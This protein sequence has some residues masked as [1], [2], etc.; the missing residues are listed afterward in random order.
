MQSPENGSTRLHVRR[1]LAKSNSGWGHLREMPSRDQHWEP[2]KS[3]R[4]RASAQQQGEPVT[5][6][7]DDLIEALLG[8][9]TDSERDGAV[10]YLA[11]EPV[12][13]GEVVNV[14]GIKIHFPWD[15]ALAFV[16][17]EPMANWSHSAR[18]LLLS[19]ATGKVESIE[20]RLPPFGPTADRR[21]RL[22]RKPESIPDGVLPDLR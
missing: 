7:D 2:W 13:A 4:Q 5:L 17:R 15:G 6:S 14:P 22:A 9:L 8:A 16:D 11:I 21:W 19:A 12:E 10:I 1:P 18:Y 20:A 3:L